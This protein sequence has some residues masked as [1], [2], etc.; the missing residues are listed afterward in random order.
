MVDS[1]TYWPLCALLLA[2]TSTGCHNVTSSNQSFRYLMKLEIERNSWVA[3]L[4]CTAPNSSIS[5]CPVLV[6]A[7]HLNSPNKRTQSQ[8]GLIVTNKA[9]WKLMGFFCGR[10][11]R[12]PDVLFPRVSHRVH[13]LLMHS[14]VP[15]P[16]PKSRLALPDT[17]KRGVLGFTH[18]GMTFY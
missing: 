15:M 18:M 3:S 2:T 13:N 9:C 11:L 6:K 17:A 14:L 4:S 10:F 5:F 12:T 7:P 16:N 8:Q 1:T